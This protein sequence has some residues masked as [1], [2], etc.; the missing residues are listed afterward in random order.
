VHC[1]GYDVTIESEINSSQKTDRLPHNFRSD[2]DISTMNSIIPT[3][4]LTLLALVN[5]GQACID[6]SIYY[7]IDNEIEKIA[8]SINAE[9]QLVHF[10]GGIVR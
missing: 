10:Y 6:K 1:S 8:S 2:I 4:L 3:A 5:F 7:E 9:E